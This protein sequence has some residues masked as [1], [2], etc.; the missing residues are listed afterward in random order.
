METKDSKRSLERLLETLGR[1]R[2][3]SPGTLGPMLGAFVVGG[4]VG[5]TLAS[6]FASGKGDESRKE[7]A[8]RVDEALSAY[9]TKPPEPAKGSPGPPAPSRGA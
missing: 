3:S 8:E 4:I 5:A 2:S 9:D 6:F 7:M 1:Q